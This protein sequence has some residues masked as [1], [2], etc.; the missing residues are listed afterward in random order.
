MPAM[1]LS[2]AGSPHAVGRVDVVPVM[3]VMPGVVM[4]LPVVH[5]VRPVGRARCLRK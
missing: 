1:P 2:R 5:A 3:V 4:V